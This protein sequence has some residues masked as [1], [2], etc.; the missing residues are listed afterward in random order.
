MLPLP[1][2]KTRDPKHLF[3]FICYMLADDASTDIIDE[4]KPAGKDTSYGCA[5]LSLVYS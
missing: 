1:K 2:I 3:R 5:Y 4:S